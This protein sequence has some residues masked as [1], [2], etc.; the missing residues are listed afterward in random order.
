M[1][2]QSP[3]APRSDDSSNH[4]FEDQQM[5]NQSHNDVVDEIEEIVETAEDHHHVED[6]DQVDDEVLVEIKEILLHNKNPPLFSESCCIYKVPHQ[7]RKINEEAYTPKV[8]SIGPLHCRNPKLQNMERIKQFAFKTFIDVAKDKANTRMED[9]IKFVRSAE[10]K[11]R[12][13]YSENIVL[14][15]SQLVKLILVDASF[16]IMLFL[17]SRWHPVFKEGLFNRAFPPQVCKDL[18]L[19]SFLKL[20]LEFFSDYNMQNIPLDQFFSIKHFTDLLRSFYLPMLYKPKRPTPEFKQYGINFLSHSAS[21]LHE[22]GVKLKASERKCLLELKFSGRHLEIP[23]ILLHHKTET[24]FRNMIALEQCHYPSKPYI[25]DYALLMD[26]LINTSKDVDVLVH[27]DI[28]S[29]MLGDSSDVVKLFN[30]LCKDIGHINFNSDYLKICT[31][32]NE[33]YKNRW[34]N[35]KATFR[36]QYC[37][38]P[39]KIAASIAAIVLLVLTII[40]TICSVI[41]VA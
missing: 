30:G 36:N 24:I 38:T 13:F 17:S 10:P 41:Q 3:I 34:N 39:W 11:V 2:D 21:E 26:C 29:N 16:I 18:K 31:G 19:P 5:L 27:Q 28:I 9:L 4:H 1:A 7:I 14:R 12:A 8:V 15:E 35:W 33:F 40:Q 20:T 32:L 37:S 22:K 6:N 23:Q 25:T